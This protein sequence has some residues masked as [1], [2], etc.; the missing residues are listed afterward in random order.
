M[1]QINVRP[2]I[3]RSHLN[4]VGLLRSAELAHWRGYERAGVSAGCPGRRNRP[5]GRVMRGQE[6]GEGLHITVS[7][8]G[9]SAGSALF[10]PPPTLIRTS[11]KIGTWTGSLGYNYF[12]LAI[13]IHWHTSTSRQSSKNAKFHCDQAINTRDRNLSDT[14]IN[15][16]YINVIENSEVIFRGILHRTYRER[17]M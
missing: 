5:I 10:G 4:E 7:T 13:V 15:N 8:V 11:G 14:Q 6:S 2:M 17:S 1:Y 9:R 12:V 3:T 16:T